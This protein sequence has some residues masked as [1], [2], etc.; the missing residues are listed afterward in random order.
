LIFENGAN[1]NRSRVFTVA[2]YYRFKMAPIS[3]AMPHIQDVASIA[4]DKHSRYSQ[5]HTY[6]RFESNA[7]A[8][9][10]TCDFPN[11]PDAV[12]SLHFNPR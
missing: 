7:R 9:A 12:S 2:A 5:M 3:H 6:Q 10:N 11:I 4:Y 8:H 1:N